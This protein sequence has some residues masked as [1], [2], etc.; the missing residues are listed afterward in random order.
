MPLSSRA[1]AAAL[2]A[3]PLLLGA[4]AQAPAPSLPDLHWRLLGPFRGGWSTMAVG[5]PE[6]PD[7]YYFGAA[8]GGVWK[9][10]NAGRTWEAVADEA[11]IVSVGAIAIAPSDSRVIYADSGQPEP[12]YDIAAGDGVYRSGDS[13]HT[14][15][16][17]GLEAPRYLSTILV[18]PQDPNVVTVAAPGH[19]FGPDKN[20]GVYRSSDGGRTWTQTLFID[21]NT[22]VVDL[23]ADPRHP[24][25]VYAAAWQA[26]NWPWLSYFTPMVGQAS[27]LYKSADGGRTW[28]PLRGEGWPKSALGRIGLAVTDTPLG[29]RI[30]ATVD[31]EEDGGIWRSDDGGAHWQRVNNDGDMFGSWYF[32]RITVAPDNPDVLYTSG[33][34][35][36]RS[37]DAGKTFVVVKGAPG[38]DDYHGL[39][40]N[41]KHP[42]HWIT[43]SD[44]GT[45]ISVDAGKTWSDWYNQPTGQFYHLA[46]DKRF[47][48]WIYSGQQDSGTVGIASRSDY[49]ALTFRDWQPVGGD[50]RDYDIPDPADPLTVYGSGLGGRISRWDARTGQV[51]NVSPWP[52]SSYGK[53]PTTVKYR[54]TWIA[55][56]VASTQAPYA[57]YA[58]AQ[59]LFRST[60]RGAHWQ[61]ISPDLTGADPKAQHCE[62]DV[63]ITAARACGY[64]VIYSIGLSPRDGKL[65]WVGTDDGLIQLSRDGGAHWAK[66]TPADLPDWARVNSVDPSALDAGTAYAVADNHRQDDFTPHVW[67][68]HDFGKTWRSI[69]A[70]LPPDHFVAVVRADPQQAGLLYA[71]TDTGVYVSFDDGEHWRDLQLNLP[72]A[73]VRDLLVHG[74]D[75][76]AATQGR[77]LWVLDD[78]SPL[79][80]MHDGADGTPIRLL[81]PASAYRLRGDNNR[82]TPLP[83]ETPQGGN[84]PAG[85]TIDY[86]VDADE[87]GPVSLEIRDAQGQLVRRFSSDDK[88]PALNAERYFSEAW[89]KPAPMLSA[90]PGWHRF[91]WNLR[92]P[93]PQAIAYDYTIAATYG[94]DT[95]VLPQGPFVLPGRYQVSLSAGDKVA[96]APLLIQL[97]PRVKATAAQLQQSLAFSMAVGNALGQ[98]YLAKAEAQ[99]VVDQ[100]E[101][102]KPKLTGPEAG[103]ALHALD[104]FL[105]DAEPLLKKSPGSADDLAS[106]SAVLAGLE[107]DAESADVAPTTAQRNVLGDY[108]TRLG[109]GIAVWRTLRTIRLDTLNAQLQGSGLGPVALPSADQLRA[110]APDGGKDLP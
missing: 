106:L 18:D 67:R 94:Q 62:G 73:W 57:L 26:R 20:R 58:G 61:T 95:P 71:G 10:E 49:G 39:W 91:I 17:V 11:G 66:V 59:V 51:A 46:A 101:S 74:D 68:T 80:R 105:A 99:A 54:Y 64:G 77:A 38:G 25:E 98:A 107:T 109:H 1:A 110:D 102:I 19:L 87:K 104:A 28:A 32:S 31:S 83:P 47:P 78:V 89:I 100:I 41:P 63:A 7:T 103:P 108:S 14:W 6:Q 37:T 84:P 34:S 93:Q 56:L 23:A 33:Q 55:P 8:G 21:D 82:D 36:R 81:P 22:G 76:I 35:I 3:V 27:G 45:V 53:R 70:G 50:E 96:Q 69:T 12:R 4:A 52:V 5:V 15:Q 24:Q 92:Y 85:A 9:T 42:D 72:H 40:I 90:A 29:T 13:G 97:D 30:Y 60:D 16:H 88:P 75:L 48:Y 2:I 86:F 44:Q 79:R 65:I 43:A